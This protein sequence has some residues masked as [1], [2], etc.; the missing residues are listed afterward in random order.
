LS[1]FK[2]D[3]K[4]FGRSTW[5][6]RTSNIKIAHETFKK[7]GYKKLLNSYFYQAD[8][9]WVLGEVDKTC[10]EMTVSAKAI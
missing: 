10:N 9:C 3:D 4:D 1:F 8:W 6:R 7:V 5:I 2:P